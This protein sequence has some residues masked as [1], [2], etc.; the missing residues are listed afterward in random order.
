MS[1]SKHLRGAALLAVLL[2]TST[3]A[4]SQVAVVVGQYSAVTSMT[5]DQVASV[6]LGKSKALPNGAAAAPV[7]QPES[8]AIRGY[9]YKK[10]TGMD[11]AQ[12]KA[13]WARMV[14]TGKAAPPR[15]VADSTAVKWFVA[16]NPGAIGYIENSAVDASVR[17]VLAIP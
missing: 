1:P 14:F 15:A 4:C 13:S 11:P 17:V 2:A 10:L 16:N 6:F 9:F 12:V 8:T 7:D 5:A 3:W